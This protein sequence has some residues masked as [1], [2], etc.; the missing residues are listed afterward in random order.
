[1]TTVKILT[2]LAFAYVLTELA[3]Q[4]WGQVEPPNCPLCNI[5]ECD[6]D[7][8]V[9]KSCPGA[10]LV[11]DPCGCCKRCGRRFGET[12]GGAYEYIGRCELNLMCTASPS[13]Y[14]NGANISGV[15][16]SEY[17][18]SIIQCSILY[19]YTW[20]L[21]IYT[22]KFSAGNTNT[23]IAI[24][25]LS[26]MKSSVYCNCTFACSYSCQRMYVRVYT[27]R[28]RSAFLWSH[29]SAAEI[30]SQYTLYTPEGVLD[31]ASAGLP[32]TFLWTRS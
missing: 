26:F 10:Q 25:L 14:L 9:Q 11:R 20:C 7:T 8:V 1:M 28:A 19:N 4:V 30:T 12:C 23:Y 18:N 22:R 21:M 32:M 3:V 29:I 27:V 6:N 31:S 5:R 17:N 16:T 2:L 15:C 13:E 24:I